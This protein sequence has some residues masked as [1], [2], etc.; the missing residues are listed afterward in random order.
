MTFCAG[1]CRLKM[2]VKLPPVSDETSPEILPS[3]GKW[4]CTV[5]GNVIVSE[6]T[7]LIT[8]GNLFRRELTCKAVSDSFI[9]RI[10]ATN[11]PEKITKRLDIA[12]AM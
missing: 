3:Y 4:A 12:A 9:I 7:L 6:M 1:V 10:D 8:P 2:G 11:Y 5:Q